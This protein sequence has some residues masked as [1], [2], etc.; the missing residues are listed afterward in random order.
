MKN[1]YTRHGMVTQ[2]NTMQP[3]TKV[4]LCKTQRN[5]TRNAVGKNTE[6]QNSKF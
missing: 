4:V 2:C 6:G 5:Y 3:G 1:G